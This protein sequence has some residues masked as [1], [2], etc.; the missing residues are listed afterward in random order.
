MKLFPIRTPPTTYP[1]FMFILGSL[2][3]SYVHFSKGAYIEQVL[4]AVQQFSYFSTN[5]CLTSSRQ[6]SP[7]TNWLYFQSTVKTTIS[8]STW[9]QWPA[10]QFEVSL[11]TQHFI[12]KSASRLCIVYVASSW[13]NRSHFPPHWP[14]ILGRWSSRNR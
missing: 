4:F 3:Y 13:Q 10:K 6:K 12:M 5:F 8:F 7:R 14:P 11:I 1:M 2:L 9:N